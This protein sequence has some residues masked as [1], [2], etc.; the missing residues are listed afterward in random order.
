MD[1][2]AGIVGEPVGATISP[3]RMSGS[4]SPCT[5]SAR[6]GP[7]ELNFTHSNEGGARR[8]RGTR[9]PPDHGFSAQYAS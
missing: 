1:D 2:V 3:E 9:E 7:H 5:A 4:R 8:R 6:R